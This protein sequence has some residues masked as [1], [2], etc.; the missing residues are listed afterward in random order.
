MQN[1]TI[2]T[3]QEVSTRV[4]YTGATG[5]VLFGVALEFWGVIFGLIVGVAGFLV[6]WYYKHKAHKLLV[7]RYESLGIEEEE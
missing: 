4:Q 2:Q 7:K 3:I 6:N 5:A 1:E